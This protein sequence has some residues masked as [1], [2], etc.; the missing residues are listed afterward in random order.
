MAR[1]QIKRVYDPPS[2]T[3]GERFLVDRLWPRGL[4]KEDLRLAAWFKEAAPSNALR[5]WFHR[6]PSKW[7][8]FQR[9]YFAELEQHPQTWQPLVEAARRG[10]ITLLFSSK[11]LERN[12]AVVL[13]RFLERKAAKN[14]A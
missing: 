4:K 11:N 12:N 3:D 5:Q 9:R 1:I 10:T 8:E 6:D 2:P 14:A 7:A 13:K